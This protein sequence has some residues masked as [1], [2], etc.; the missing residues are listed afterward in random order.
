MRI[1]NTLTRRK[2][3]FKPIEPGKVRMYV[4]GPTVYDKAHVG[5]AMSSVTF[6]I[7]RRHLEY[8]GFEVNHVMNYTDVEDKIIARA[9]EMGLEPIRL[10]EKYMHE[11]EQH[12]QELNVLPARQ[13]PRASQEIQPIIDMISGL[14][15][16][17]H[18]YVVDGD[19]YFRVL[20][21][22]QYGK[23]SGRKLED[24]RA[25]FRK[26]VDQRKEEHADFALWKTAKPGEPVWEAPWGQ[27]RPGWHIECSSMC[28]TYLGEEI[29][30]HGGGNDLIFPHHENEIAQS[31]CFS[32]KPFARYWMHNGMLQLAGEKMSK[33]VGDLITIDA[34]LEEHSADIFR[35]VVLNS[36][37]RSPLTFNDEVLEQAHKALARLMGA[38]RE[39]GG[40]V[41]GNPESESVL[42][43]QVSQTTAAF[44]SAMDEDFNA[45][46]ALAALFDLARTIN[47]TR[48][49]GGSTAVLSL[50]RAE[51]RR[52]AG[53]LGLRLEE[54]TIGSAGAAPFID[55]LVD[56]RKRLRDAQ[57]WD[58]ADLIRDELER[59]DVRIEDSKGDTSWR[60]R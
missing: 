15:E 35:M 2:E 55:V 53:N 29:D 60:F 10:A 6:D 54:S 39:N 7:I 45:P 32:G 56:V 41:H 5:H 50:A 11:Y 36:H 51:L 59:L 40:S 49:A 20:S 23:L 16:N 14:I 44:E 26:D 42:R 22:P 27:G 52:L 12:L 13:Y 25:G 19:V 43:A 48:D 31:E 21:A 24:M 30:I 58:L 46:S 17:E 37:Y 3:E 1:Y 47:Q 28:L 4:C 38:L 33:S 8:R 34:F 18:A 9:N 57:Q